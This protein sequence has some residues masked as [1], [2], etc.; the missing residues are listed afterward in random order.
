MLLF[1]VLNVPSKHKKTA[2][3]PPTDSCF[4]ITTSR[5]DCYFNYVLESYSFEITTNSMRLLSSF[6]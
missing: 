4:T 2:I 6:S 3:G 1:F 5:S